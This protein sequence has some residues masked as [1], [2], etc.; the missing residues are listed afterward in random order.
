MLDAKEEAPL[1]KNQVVL[2]RALREAGVVFVLTGDAALR[3]HA[4][5]AGVPAPEAVRR[6]GFLPAHVAVKPTT[7]NV[8]KLTARLGTLSGIKPMTDT[9]LHD[10]AELAREGF[11][12]ITIYP[13]GREG[14]RPITLSCC[15]AEWLRSY[16]NLA[17]DSTEM[18]FGDF[19]LPVAS[20]TAVEATDSNERIVQAAHELRQAI[21]TGS[22]SGSA[23]GGA[24]GPSYTAAAASRPC[25]PNPPGQKGSTTRR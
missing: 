2:L 25:G 17:E 22:S 20:V 9:E 7:E 13:T 1:S 24:T 15:P 11:G 5:R 12:D 23:S 6:M 4:H 19:T 16:D 14:P 10:L 8:E 21:E 3:A 18:D